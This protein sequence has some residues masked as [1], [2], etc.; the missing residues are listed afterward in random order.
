MATSE[1]IRKTGATDQS[2]TGVPVRK[3]SRSGVVGPSM[4]SSLIMMLNDSLA[5]LIAFAAA[6]VLRALIF[7]KAARFSDVPRYT[8]SAPVGLVCLM[9]F[10]LAYILVAH[11]YGLY[12]SVPRATGA[13]E[14]RLIV[15][16]CFN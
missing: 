7:D 4:V 5:I 12:S 1:F 6:L 9:S 3:R 13:H 14:I 2:A 8:I 11:R 15:Q 16:G 10:I